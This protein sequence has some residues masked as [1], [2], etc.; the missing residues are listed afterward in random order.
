MDPRRSGQDVLQCDLCENPSPNMY[1]DV[2]HLNLCKVCVG[3]H[4]S[5]D[6]IEHRVVSFRKRGFTFTCPNHST[7]I[8]ELHC[9]ACDGPICSLCVSSGEHDQHKKIDILK[10]LES[11]KGEIKE[12]LQE[13]EKNIYPTYQ[14]FASIIPVKKDRMRENIQKLRSL[15]N[16]QGEL[17]HI[18]ID[19]FIEKLRW[20]L[21][22]Y[23]S[24][25]V[26]ALNRQ[27]DEYA[28]RISEI[29]QSIED[30]KRA[31]DSN[32]VSVVSSY[33]SK[34]DRFRRLPDQPVVTLPKFFPH[35]INKIR[36]LVQENF[37]FL[38]GI[39]IKTEEQGYILKS[40]GAMSSPLVRTLIDVQ[41]II[42]NTHIQCLN[43]NSL[44]SVVCANNEEFWTCRHDNK[45]R[46]YNFH[47]E[48][49]K[50][51]QTKTGS[52]PVDI[53]VTKSGDLVYTDLQNRTVNIVKNTEISEVIRLKKWR[54]F[55]ICC[56][57]SG[58]ILVVMDNLKGNE[59]KV[60]R[61]SGSTEKQSIQFDGKGQRLYSNLDECEC[62]KYIVENRNLDICVA[63]GHKHA[64]IVVNRAGEFRF[65]YT[66]IFRPIGITTD[67]QGRILAADSHN[68]R[69]HILDQDGHFLRY[70][71]NCELVTPWSLSIDNDDI[72]VVMMKNNG[73]VK[74]IQYCL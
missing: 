9:E 27:E 68:N 38:S 20:R 30:L 39:F 65:R 50:S 67:S 34:N 8:C 26:S 62:T 58:D 24:N 51:I 72:L 53:A 60:V 7:K 63:D 49:V 47:G 46:L 35:D 31:Y 44:D 19:M 69:I 55:Y 71:D 17:W 45:I 54:P 42:A 6:S 70:I 48:L 13:L 74:K 2:C 5:D 52:K 22:R 61:Y 28:N 57:S 37:S 12:Y 56:S 33:K 4:L 18:E 23:D 3:E 41:R 59:S 32:D 16:E 11:K 14:K 1:C 15:I 25:I 21:D 36:I 29:K 66:G 43:C 10:H 73:N 64:I 40:P